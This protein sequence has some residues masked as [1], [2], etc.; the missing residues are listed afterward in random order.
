MHPLPLRVREPPRL[1]VASGRCRR[2]PGD[3][4]RRRGTGLQQH[5][6]VIAVVHA[7][8]DRAV[9]ADRR[10]G[11]RARLRVQCRDLV[12]DQVVSVQAVPPSL[13]LEQQERGGVRPPVHGLHG[14]G[15]INMEVPDLA[16][17][18]VPGR[19]PALAEALVRDRHAQVTRHRRE[20]VAGEREPL[21][22]ELRDRPAGLRV[23]GP[24]RGME[25]VA[26][27]HDLQHDH[28]IVRGQR[29]AIHGSCQAPASGQADG[30]GVLMEQPHGSPV[31]RDPEAVALLRAD[32]GERP[33]A[34]DAQALGP[35]LRQ[36][37][38][39]RLRRRVLV[40]RRDDERARLRASLVPEPDHPGPV[41][42]WTAL[43]HAHGV[44]RYL[45]PFTRGSV[46]RV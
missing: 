1:E 34:A 32:R 26:V 13:Q 31:V 23:H 3:E 36:P 22:L 35:T 27:F 46:P 30:L 24:E 43:Q 45:A 20:A 5:G 9:G 39:Q 6:S 15:Q 10:R 33:V 14:P 44:V 42:R 19:R 4:Q 21:V 17:R 28:A 7:V 29:P 8:P 25:H 37:L 16:G 41:P 12:R 38:E 40:E 2:P 11:D 18:H